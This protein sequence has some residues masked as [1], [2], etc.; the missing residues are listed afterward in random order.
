[1]SAY[2]EYLELLIARYGPGGQFWTENPGLP[3]RPIRT[4]QIWNEPHQ[5][6]QW[7]P[8]TNWEAR[9]GEL[10]RAAHAAVKRADPGA[11]VVLAGMADASWELLDQLYDRGGIKGHF[12]VMG[13]HYYEKNS[14]EFVEVS[15]RV[16]ETLDEHGDR[17][18]PIWWTEAGASASHGKV[19]GRATRHFRTTDKGM[20]RHLTRT[21]KLLAGARR[22]LGIQRVYWYTWASSY[23]RGGSVFDYAGLNVFDGRRVKAKPARVAYRN[24]A[25]RF[26]GC[27]KDSRARCVRR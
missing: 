12:D 9:Y 15:K 27:R 1:V 14:H 18:V 4:W 20:A 19:S 16:R 17:R 10:L 2:V 5:P 13:V 21:Y 11:K 3:Y 22:R 25:R 24:I 6:Y 26:E 7:S 8:Q 23:R